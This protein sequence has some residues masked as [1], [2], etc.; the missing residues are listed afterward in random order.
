ML[1]SFL[2]M[3]TLLLTLLIFFIATTIRSTFGFGDAL[4]TMP[5]LTIILGIQTATPLFALVAST[6]AL[7][8][9]LFSRQSIDFK[10]AWRL[11]IATVVGIPFGILLLKVAPEKIVIKALGV[12]LIVFGIYRLTR[13]ELPRLTNGRW[14][15]L[16]GFIAGI[17][18]SAY[19]TNG[20]PI[21][22]YGTMQRWNPERFRA[23]LQGYF[24]PSGLV[25]IAS[26]SLNHLWTLN[27]FRLYLL[28]L[29]V[30]LI[31]TLIGGKLNQLIPIQRF[32]R[33]LFTIFIFLGV[34][35]L[36]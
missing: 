15:Y 31:A 21:V 14:A 1:P 27:V 25:I 22:I 10:A 24:L 4:I 8:I 28:A 18:G 20:P 34:L 36:I 16:F 5:L 32:G 11:V 35:L 3:L 29:P 9:V 26:H 33:L 12:F 7:I 13:S 6:V 30:V 17:L 2:K 19:N 23:T